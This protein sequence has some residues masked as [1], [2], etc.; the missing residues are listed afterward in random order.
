[1][2]NDDDLFKGI[3]KESVVKLTGKI[4]KKEK[5]EQKTI[6]SQLEMLKWLLIH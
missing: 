4:R 3:A 2:S 5:K 1:M 6:E